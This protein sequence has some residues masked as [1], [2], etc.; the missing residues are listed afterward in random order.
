MERAIIIKNY[1]LSL[2]PL[3]KEAFLTYRHTHREIDSIRKSMLPL[4]TNKYGDFMQA[5]PS[6]KTDTAK[7]LED[8]FYAAHSLSPQTTDEGYRI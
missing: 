2:S 5:T 4:C 3:C 6:A 8:S 7:Q 1:L